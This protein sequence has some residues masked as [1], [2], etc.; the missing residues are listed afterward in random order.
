MILPHQLVQHLAGS[1]HLAAAGLSMEDVGKYWAH[2]GRHSAWGTNHPAFERG[3][4]MP[5]F[6]P[7]LTGPGQL[8]IPVG[9]KEEFPA[10]ALSALFAERGL[11][12]IRSDMQHKQLVDVLLASASLN[13]TH[14]LRD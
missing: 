14:L 10:D 11:G 2:M 8:W 9:P 5:M 3:R 7:A 4:H 13:A 12:I 6:L 1:G